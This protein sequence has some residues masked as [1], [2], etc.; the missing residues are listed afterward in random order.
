MRCALLHGFAG[1]PSA[2][3]DVIAAW[4]LPEPPRT[5]A[6]PGHGGGDVLPTWDDNIDHIARAV[7]GCDVAVGYSFGARV[8]L[9]LVAG[10]HVSRAVLIGVNPGIEHSERQLRRDGDR[11]WAKLLRER[12]ID[13][14]A[15]AWS[16]QPLFAS[17]AR[18]AEDKRAARTQARLA[19]DP[20]QLAQCLE[21]MSL[22]EMPDY[23]PALTRHAKD[24]ALLA[25]AD[26]AKYVAIAQ[27]LV[28][29]GVRS[30][31]TIADAGH[32]P[33]LEQPERLAH[34]IARAV[35]R[36]A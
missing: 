27:D 13:A 29:A 19:L 23:R 26:D 2:W 31:E 32:D 28:D 21:V 20:E 34:A 14:F 4:Q 6:L 5:I 7:S 10:N 16:G 9:A 33:T 25:G 24:I 36:L 15:R 30:F 17:Q 35:V 1:T 12:G 3:D 18:A 8:A 11:I 22:A